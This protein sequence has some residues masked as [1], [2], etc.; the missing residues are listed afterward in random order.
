MAPNRVT[1]KGK[2]CNIA[3]A[4]A[5]GILNSAVRNNNVAH[6]SIMLLKKT[7]DQSFLFMP[8]LKPFLKKNNETTRKRLRKTKRYLCKELR[9]FPELLAS[10]IRDNY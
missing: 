2:V 1:V 5:R 8:C 6:R 10:F 7:N 4:F 3:L 9:S